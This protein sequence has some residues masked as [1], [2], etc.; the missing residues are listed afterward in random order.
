MSTTDEYTGLASFAQAQE[1]ALMYAQLHWDGEAHGSP[2]AAARGRMDK[3]LVL[4][5]V[6]DPRWVVDGDATY[7]LASNQALLVD[8]E[9]GV[10][11]DV[12]YSRNLR[13]IK[14]MAEVVGEPLT[15]KPKAQA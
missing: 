11:Y 4:V 5:E 7:R 8:R 15:V 1:L 12:P 14:A 6:G 3:E 13:R 2:A 9:T 10:V